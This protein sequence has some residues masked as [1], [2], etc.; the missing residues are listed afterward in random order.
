MAQFLC[1]DDERTFGVWFGSG[2]TLGTL[3]KLFLVWLPFF[4]MWTLFILAYT[5]ATVAEAME[6]GAVSMGSGAL[7]GVGVWWLSGRIP[8]PDRMRPSFYLAHLAIGVVYAV[9][10]ILLTYVFF[11]VREGGNL[12][13]MLAQ[14]EVVGWRVL[15]GLWLYGLIAGICYSIRIRRRLRHQER[16]AARAEA[17]AAEARLSALRTQLNPH[18]LFN[19]LHSLSAL[20]RH[21]PSGAE[22]AIERLGDLLRYA[23]DGAGSDR[24][25]LADEW[26]FTR[27][28]LGLEGIR[29]DS[30]LRVEADFGPGTLSCLVPSFTLQ[31]L[32]ENAVQHAIAPRPDGGEIRIEAALVGETLRL[33]VRDDGPGAEVERVDR[34]H[35]H[36]LRV[37]R[38]R[39]E[40]M[41]ATD[42]TLEIRTEPGD[43]F[44]VTVRIPVSGSDAQED[45]S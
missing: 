38:E 21:D 25:P 23:L 24:V 29:Y 11:A 15:M 44:E 16:I 4:L 5:G 12:I 6:S 28:Y 18:F 33:C 39:F 27:D 41:Y 45:G 9:L 2:R 3:A 30:R 43:G 36:G 32:V 10:W 20:V 8:W 35:G 13:Q 40:A 17:L 14:I 34:G 37:L 19:A 7:L 1:M 26:A 31:P 42:A 22:H